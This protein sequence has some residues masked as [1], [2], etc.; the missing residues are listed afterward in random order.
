VRERAYD[1]DVGVMA[2]GT[3]GVI[4]RPTRRSF[5][6]RLVHW[7][8][9]EWLVVIAASATVGM[10]LV[11]ALFLQTGPH[12]A[13]I[14]VNR[15][16]VMPATGTP[17]ILPRP[18]PPGPKA[19]LSTPAPPA[20]GALPAPAARPRAEIIVGIQRELAQ[21][22][23]Y[24]GPADGIYGPK[25]DIA[26]RDFELAAGLRPSTEPNEVL[27]RAITRSNAKAPPKAPSRDPIAEL[28]T[29]STRIIAVQRA[30]AEYGFGQ[31]RASGSYDPATRSAIEEFER[32][33]RLP[34]TGQITERMTRELSAVTGR[35]LE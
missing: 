10:V 20:T 35:P 16:E 4:R 18:R 1:I 11:N 31:I 9:K 29:P 7:H 25:T 5:V 13:P 27:L 30:L 2:A 3:R 22:G 34:V 26:I 8:L 23:F 14:F 15:P 33:R 24:E 21:R 19:D 17:M 12:P 28:L 6:S 32:H